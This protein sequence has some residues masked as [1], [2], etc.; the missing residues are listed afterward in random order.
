[1]LISILVILTTLLN[2]ILEFFNRS[3]A[4]L[5]WG[6][7][8]VIYSIPH[9]LN[10]NTGKFPNFILDQAGFFVVLFNLIYF[11]S[12]II[13]NQRI[14]LDIKKQLIN[15]RKILNES[16]KYLNSLFSIYI[17]SILTLFYG[18]ILKGYSF[19]DFTWVDAI[20]YKESFIER[21]ASFASNAFSGI[22]FIIFARKEKLRFV[23][24]V[25]M[26]ISYVILF[27]SRYNI[28]PFLAPFI[29]YYMFSGNRKKIITSIVIGILTLF[30]VFLLQQVRYAGSLSNL[31]NNYT[32]SQIIENTFLFMKEGKGE[33]G[34]LNAFYYF[35]ECDNNFNN[36]G[37]MKTY[38]RLALLPFPSS[39]FTFKPRDFAMDMWEAW[40]GLP[41]L[42]GTIHPTLYGD[43]YANA[44]FF[45]IFLGVFYA[46][47]VEIND[48]LIKKS[49]LES[50]KVLYISIISTMYVLLARGAVYN[51]IANAFWSV[52]LINLTFLLLAGTRSKSI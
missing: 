46:F 14:N 10:Y 24:T 29:I 47:I 16:N 7:L 33:F 36:F 25:V 9:A 26:Y 6:I 31:F 15:P 8:F 40:M 43:I 21:V 3:I 28:I 50:K 12:R 23:L 37:Q 52:I 22:G 13:L 30:S 2:I 42:S 27:K 41:T 32:F 20:S 38:L 18:M 34:L 44:G 45:G 35:V 11:L 49:Y 51:S 4:I 17:L 19:S 1:M 48:L 39:I 5:L